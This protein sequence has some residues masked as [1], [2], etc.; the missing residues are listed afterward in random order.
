MEK[1]TLS[2]E[3]LASLLGKDAGSLADTLKN[4]EGQ[5]KSDD[6]IQDFV[7]SEITKKIDAAKKAGKDESYG[8]AK[9]ETAE[10][11]EKKIAE[12]LGVE[13]SDIESMVD[14]W[15]DT[16]QKK[17]KA[18]KPEDIKNSDVYINDIKA[19]REKY[20]SLEDKFKADKANWEQEVVKDQAMRTGMDL[21]REAGFILPEDS[22]RMKNQLKLFFSDL[23]SDPNITLKKDDDKI[24]VLDKDG[25]PIRND[26]MDEVDFNTFIT[27]KADT[28]FDKAAP[29][30]KKSPGNK[31]DKPGGDIKIPEFKTPEEF[32][33]ALDQQSDDKVKDK[34]YEVYTEKI[35]SGEIVE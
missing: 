16:N 33:S 13:K 34:M 23:L 35:K 22:S 9:R 25:N 20:K 21:I 2:L 28:Y 14:T 8:R 18:T 11:I 12:K 15:I 31:T 19:E 17:F 7:K 1:V 6:D 4:A 30:G 29:G 3:F 27:S 26:L 24:K 32:M 10:D 5:Q